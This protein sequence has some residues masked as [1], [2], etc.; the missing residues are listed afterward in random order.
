MKQNIAIAISVVALLTSA[1]PAV[2]QQ[3]PSTFQYNVLSRIHVL[4]TRVDC[5]SQN[6]QYIRNGLYP[7]Q[8]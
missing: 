2:A 4:E 7:S 3:D 6:D 1:V 5:L 8:C